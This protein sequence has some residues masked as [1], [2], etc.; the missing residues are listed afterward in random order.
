MSPADGRSRRGE[1]RQGRNTACAKS[2][3]RGMPSRK[4]TFL[5]PYEPQPTLSAKLPLDLLSD[6]S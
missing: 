6:P 5:K 4:F 2:S 1:L 3:S